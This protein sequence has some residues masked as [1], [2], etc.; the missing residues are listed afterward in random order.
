[1][2]KLIYRVTVA[3]EADANEPL[4]TAERLEALR[5]VGEVTKVIASKKV[6]ASEVPA[7]GA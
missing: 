5:K 6:K 7:V 3:F 2:S 4:E 1:M